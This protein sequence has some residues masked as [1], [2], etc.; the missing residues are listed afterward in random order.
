MEVDGKNLRIYAEDEAIEVYISPREGK[1]ISVYT[2]DVII[3]TSVI[4]SKN[5]NHSFK[6]KKTNGKKFD[7]ELSKDG[8]V[9]R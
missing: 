4:L 9:I 8:V 2:D 5:I 1:W 6:L 7:I 3:R